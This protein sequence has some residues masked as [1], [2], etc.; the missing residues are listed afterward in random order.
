MQ[1]VQGGGERPQRM[2]VSCLWVDDMLDEV[3]CFQSSDVAPVV[4][5]EWID[6]G[7]YGSL[8][9]GFINQY[10]CSVCGVRADYCKG[11]YCSHCGAKMDGG[12]NNG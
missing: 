5:G 1:A 4:H 10:R 8:N 6:D 11:A 9:H 3:D 2:L 7:G 12:D